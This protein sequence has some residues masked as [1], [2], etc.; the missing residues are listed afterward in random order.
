MSGLLADRSEDASIN[1]KQR[2][3]IVALVF[4]MFWM[5]IFEGSIRKWV[6]P[7]WSS[8]LY[9][10]RDPV[11]LLIYYMAARARV[12]S[13]LHPLLLVGGLLAGIAMVFSAINLLVGGT[14][15]SPILALYGFRNYFFY[16]PLPFVVYR[17]FTYADLCRLARHSIIA[18][19]IA[20]PIAVLQFRA[21]PE[22]VLNVGI[23]NDIEFQ[24]SNLAS[25]EGRV[26]PA[27]TF[28]SVMG[29]T[30]LIVSTLA[31]LLWCAMTRQR[32]KPCPKWLLAVGIAAVTVALAVSG[33]R[34]AFL[35]AAL[36][37]AAVIGMGLLRASKTG[38]VGAIVLPLL[39]VICFVAVFPRLFPEA[40]STFME[41]W[42]D[43]AELE[44]EQFHFGWVG[45]VLYSFYDFSRLIGQMP[46]LGYGVGMAGNGAVNMGVMIDGQSV[47]KL[48]EEDWS[49][50][51]IE[52]GPL[53]A[54]A[55]IAYRVSFALWLGLRALKATAQSG[56]LLAILLYAY[57]VVALTE[58]QLTGHGL[59][60]GFGWIYV[61]VC[62]AAANPKIWV[63]GASKEIA[64]ERIAAY[65]PRFPN[66]MT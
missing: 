64:Q 50:H 66:L 43:A 28:T 24:F 16:L 56:E 12:F 63:R 62:M 11:A 22:S 55:F 38:K 45:R 7:H 44:G 41:R 33:S 23:A 21:P 61:G 8:Y 9:F 42:S 29:M 17:V 19:A 30:Q 3:H 13:P 51:V 2:R 4:I 59:V 1:P 6:A 18:L 32:D 40:Y 35:Q 27:G 26:R 47:L 25:G 53:L 65:R 48:A 57:V 60:N 52:L 46:L 15:Y 39:L 58:G 34:T 37:V 49:R 54:V 10:M 20:A 5:L 14:Q 36:V 31:L